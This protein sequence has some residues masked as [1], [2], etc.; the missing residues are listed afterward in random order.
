MGELKTAL[1]DQINEVKAELTTAMADMRSE[2]WTEV[3]VVITKNKFTL[4]NVCTYNYIDKGRSEDSI[5][6]ASEDRLKCRNGRTEGRGES[7]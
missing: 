7:A 6:C 4:F 5:G 3:R 1:T 2:Q